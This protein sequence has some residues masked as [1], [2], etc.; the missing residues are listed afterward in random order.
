MGL[1]RQFFAASVEIEP[2]G[3]D[4]D[5]KRGG[6]AARWFRLPTD[7]PVERG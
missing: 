4:E 7:S 1:F 3:H 6:I 5:R 2:L